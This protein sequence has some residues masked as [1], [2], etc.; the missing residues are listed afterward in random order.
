MLVLEGIPEAILFLV[1]KGLDSADVAQCLGSNIAQL[2][3]LT[4]VGHSELVD[5]DS[6]DAGHQDLG[7]DERDND[8]CKLD[9]VGEQDAGHNKNDASR[10]DSHRNVS[11]EP[12]LHNLCI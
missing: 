5:E 2:S 11:C 7:N 1:R 12:I 8:E 10:F 6:T 3:L 9:V 4:L